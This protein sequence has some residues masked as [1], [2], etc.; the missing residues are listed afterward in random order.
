M[1]NP[2][3]SRIYQVTIAKHGCT[4]DDEVLN[5]LADSLEESVDKGYLYTEFLD[6]PQVLCYEVLSSELLSEI[7]VGQEYDTVEVEIIPEVENGGIG[8]D[9]EHSI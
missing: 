8:Y 3:F 9:E 4:D 5:I 6:E 1:S 7:F 2:I